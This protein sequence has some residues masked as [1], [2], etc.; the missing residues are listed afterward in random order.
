VTLV[1]RVQR[2]SNIESEITMDTKLAYRPNEA[3]E[4]L[5]VSKGTLYAMLKSGELKKVKIGR[6]T[7]ISQVEL[8]RY[9][10]DNASR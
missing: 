5:S 1:A 7:L 4:I 6:A 2:G 9:L 10:A 8:D 3:A